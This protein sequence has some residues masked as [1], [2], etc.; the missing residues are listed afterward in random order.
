L[1][2]G[3]S[4]LRKAEAKLS[5]GKIRMIWGRDHRSAGAELPDLVVV[6]A[7][8][9]RLVGV[10]TDA[11]NRRAEKDDLPCL[12]KVEPGS[13]LALDHQGRSTSSEAYGIGNVLEISSS[14]GSVSVD[15]SGPLIASAELTHEAIRACLDCAGDKGQQD[16]SKKQ[17]VGKLHF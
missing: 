9:V 13:G 12:P 4:F 3:L 16:K 5:L 17:E 15:P 1:I 2:N 6:V 7:N 8:F 10:F 14:T 11:A